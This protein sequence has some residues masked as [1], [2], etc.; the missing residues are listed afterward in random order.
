MTL[1]SGFV[2][3]WCSSRG[4]AIGIG[5]QGAQFAGVGDGAAVPV[6]SG[7]VRPGQAVV[8]R[9]VVSCHGAL[10]YVAQHVAVDAT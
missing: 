3:M 4:P 8:S 9:R 10:R 5:S 7:H 1:L 2:I 6:L